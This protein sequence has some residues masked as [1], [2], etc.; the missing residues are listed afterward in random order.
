[1]NIDAE[2]ASMIKN[3]ADTPAIFA[4]TNANAL[5][6]ELLGN[7]LFMTALGI[8]SRAFLPISQL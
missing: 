7:S 5:D 3:I 2:H 6:I 1:M 8:A 4:M